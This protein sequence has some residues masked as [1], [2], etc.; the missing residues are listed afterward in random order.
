[1]FEPAVYHAPDFS[2][3]LFCHAPDVQSAPCPADGVA[4]EGFHATSMYPE[5][6]K[7]RGQWQLAA[8]SRMDCCVVISADGTLHVTEP[9][10]LKAADRVILGRSEDG[11]E[12]IY[13]H[14]T[15]F[16]SEAEAQEA[17][18]FRT[19]RSRE[20]AFSRDYDRFYDLLEYERENGFIVWVL[21][22]AL[23]FDSDSR[24]AMQQLIQGGY[25]HG[26]LAGNAMATH[27]LEAGW[28][29]TALGQDIYTHASVPLGHYHHLDTINRVRRLGGIKNFVHEAGICDGVMAACVQKDVPYVL[30]GSIRDDGP[31]PEVFANVYQ[32][33]DA[34]RNLVRRATTIVCL[35]T[36]LHTIA[37][38]NMTPSFRVMPDGSVRPV[39]LYVV[40]VAEFAVNKLRDRGSLSATGIVAN[41]QD[42]IVNAAKGVGVY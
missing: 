15:G 30:A 9:R 6:Y 42:F 11:S 35:A 22:P 31:L 17:F 7:L 4:P 38:G 24:R 39:Y 2:A 23:V 12:G 29:H 28:L 10:R 18:A 27:D 40:D 20:T 5:Y 41:V 14:A 32:A 26:L 21:G 37:T 1:M 3:P 16:C 36:Q 33:Q 8:D 34:M 13:L 19:G 25:A